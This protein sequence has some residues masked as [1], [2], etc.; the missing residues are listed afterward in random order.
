MWLIVAQDRPDDYV[1]ATGRAHSVREFVEVAFAEVGPGSFGV[2]QASMKRASTTPPATCWSRL[3]ALLS[4]HRGGH[5]GWGSLKGARPAR[6][7]T[8]VQSQ[9]W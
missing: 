3:T 6:L 8:S 7:G 1:L 4:P 2:E 9:N 5:L